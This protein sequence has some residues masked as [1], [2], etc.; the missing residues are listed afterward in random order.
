MSALMRKSLT[1]LTRRKARTFFTVL[2]LSLAVASVG[3]FAVPSVMQQAMERE[4]AVNQSA[5]VTVSFKPLE[6][7]DGVLARLE[8]L[9]NVTAVEPRSS[10][11]TRVWVGERRRRAIVVGVPDYGHQRVD[12]VAIRSG[13]A[14]TGEA[15]LTEHNNAERRGFEATTGDVARLMAADGH[16]RVLPISGV[17]RNLTDGEA[18]PS[19]DWITFYGS[20]QSVA[21]LSGAPGYTTLGIRLRDN[22]RAAAE[23]TIAAV[24][25][26]LRRLTSFAGFSDLPQIRDP[27]SY[28]GQEGFSNIA[29]LFNVLTLLALVTA[30]VL[31]S[32][33]MTTL[34]GEQTGEIAAMKA[35]GA[36]RRDIR[37]VYLRTALLLGALGAVIGAALGVLLA[38]GLVKLFASMFFGVDAGFA[39]SVPVVVASALLGLAGPPVAALPAVR[40]AARLPLNEA[41]NAAGSAV[42]GQGRLDALLRRVHGVPRSVQ[43]GLRGLGRRKRRSAATAVQVS[44]AVATLLALLS[45]GAGVTK[46]TGGWFDDNHFDTWVQPVS[47]K[48]FGPEQA[49][50]IDSTPGVRVAQPWLSNTVRVA[51]QDAQAW[52]LPAKPLMNTRVAEGRWY[53]SAEA[54]A[55]ATVAVLGRTIAKTLGA[56]VGDA[57][58]VGTSGEPVT[59]RVIGISANQA[60]NGGA[61]F[62]PTATL[63]AALGTP[64]LINNY[65]VAM[66]SAEHGAIDR[67][68]TALEDRLA[69][70][71]SSVG[72]LVNYEAREQQIAANGMVT[73]TITVLGLLIVAISM[74]GLVNAITMAVLER[75]REIGML[76][77]VGARARDVRAIFGTEGL[78]VTL[79]GW[80]A[81]VPL[82]YV[83]A[84]AIGWLAGNAVGLDIAFV[85]PLGNVAI[86][87]IGTVLLALLVMLA[88]LRRAVRFKPGEAIRYA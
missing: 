18:D 72:T 53:S 82:G 11:V 38:F 79:A 29:S 87:L 64:G 74:V 2:T 24:R 81:G 39:V 62:L 16:V 77:S 51:G 10:F 65:W 31:V 49:R 20:S 63:Q 40:R 73:Q 75:T 60:D 30:L 68:T 36:R 70:R 19:N 61:I 1:D 5:D 26:E 14:P 4:V 25:A 80:L 71:G 3:L 22:R 66:T 56:G 54:H 8:R 33:T 37:R 78:V 55:G 59:L 85:F 44:L 34:I 43:I 17:G 28:P 45:V 69:G 88:P 21:A 42:G 47:S 6:L 84:R 86:A 27:G 35:I 67:T 46:I 58:R 23:Q 32:N 57:V 52:G 48:P 12:I 83:L 50:V 7:S 9:S 15:V 41:L 76:R 13:A